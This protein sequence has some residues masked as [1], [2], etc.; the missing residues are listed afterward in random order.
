MSKRSLRVTVWLLLPAVVKGMLVT[1]RRFFSRKFT[2]RYPEERHVPRKGY[3][4]EHRLKKDEQGR[5]KCV[6]CFMC[7]TACPAECITIVAGPSPWPDRDKIPVKFDIDMLKCI[8][9]GMC[10]EACPCDAIELTPTYNIVAT[11]RAEKLYDI[12]KLLSR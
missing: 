7:Q 5:M 8:Y 3:R 10:E 11:S 12:N 6:A 4:G 2:L 9:C 1:L